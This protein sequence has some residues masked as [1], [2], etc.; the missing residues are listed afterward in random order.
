VAERSFGLD[1]IRSLA[2]GLVVLGHGANFIPHPTTAGLA[3]WSGGFF[4][5]ELFF[6][7]SGF[8]IGGI[9]LRTFERKPATPAT[10]W[11]FWVRRWFRTL[12]NY[13][14]FLVLATTLFRGWFHEAAVDLRYFV[15]LQNFAWRHP[16]LMPEAWSLS[17]EEWFYVLFPLV[18]LAGAW[19]PLQR[20]HSFLLTLILYLVV[21]TA[22]RLAAAGEAASWDQDI[23]KVVIHRLDSVGYGVAAA[24]LCYYAGAWADRHARSLLAAG[25]VLSGLCAWR[26]SGFALS[27]GFDHFSKTW[28]FSLTSLGF[29]LLLPWFRNLRTRRTW[30]VRP[31]A[32]ISLVSYSMYLIHFS[33]ARPFVLQKLPE[34]P[35][36]LAY[37][38]YLLITGVVA[39]LVY[40]LFERPTTDLRDRFGARRTE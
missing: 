26:F 21:T 6:V 18:T 38:S 22:L 34:L 8:L 25:V 37:A 17:V 32:H 3:F 7:L 24:Y 1:V 20:R 40:N 19:L 9:L 2:I 16:G 35:W 12:P 14:L 29:A 39:T 11:R 23:R 27:G 4:G 13:F 31:V 5:V 36:W 15:F 28:L 30:L 10:I 33:L